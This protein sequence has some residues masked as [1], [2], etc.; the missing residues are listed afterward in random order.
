M[1]SCCARCMKFGEWKKYRGAG[2]YNGKSLCALCRVVVK[3]R[4][5]TKKKPDN[6]SR[7]R[8]RHL[9]KSDSR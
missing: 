8:Q 6:S 1:G 2:V 7:D 4:V 9:D 5:K 3:P